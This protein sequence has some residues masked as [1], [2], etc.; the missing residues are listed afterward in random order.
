MRTSVPEKLLAIVDDIDARGD[1]NLTRLT[2][3]KKWFERPGRLVPFALWV[4][5]RASSRQGKTTGEAADLFRETRK[6][7]K[8]I[9]ASQESRINPQI[10]RAAAERLYERLRTFQC[11]YRHDRWGDVRIV[12][13]W[14]L[15]LVEKAVEI[16]LARVSAAAAGYKLAADYCQNYDAK[17]GNT[18]NGPSRAKILE[19][20]RW[21]F[22]QEALEGDSPSANLFRL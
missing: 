6:L 3:L 11:D 9:S 14:Q 13:N 16:A 10:D 12:H 20:V 15:M 22:T 17:Y 18:L 21:M 7:L 4:A 2:V 19:I 5:D 1:A 8:G